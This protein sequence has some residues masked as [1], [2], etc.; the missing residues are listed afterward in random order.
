MFYARAIDN[1]I[2]PT[3]NE[4]A[5]FQATPTEQANAKITMLL[6]Y[7][8]TYPNARVPFNASDMILHIELDA[9]YLVAPKA[10]NRT[11]G[12]YYCGPNYCK[13]HTTPLHQWNHSCGM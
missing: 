9:A 11:A 13:H 4:I 3:L 5:A 1:T 7:L 2:L 8:S 6:D 12:I 10:R